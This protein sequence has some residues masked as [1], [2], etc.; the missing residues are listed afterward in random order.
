MPAYAPPKSSRAKT[1]L[2]VLIL[3]V[4][5]VLL[6]TKVFLDPHFLNSF[7]GDILLI[8]LNSSLVG[9]FIQNLHHETTQRKNITLLQKQ[10]EELDS[11]KD[12]FINMAAHELRAPLTAIKGFL[13]MVIGGD[14]GVISPEA[15]GFLVDSAVST[16]RMIRLVN[17]MLNVSR[18]EENRMFYQDED[19]HIGH[20]AHG[21]YSEFQVEAERKAL[22]FGVEMANTVN[23]L[24]FSDGD[25]LHEVLV[26]FV[27]NAIKYTEK[28]SVT[29]RI[30]NPSA[31][32][33]RL[34]VIDTGSG[35]SK[36]EQK[37]LFQKFYRV[38]AKVGKTIGTGLG[39]YIS[40][41]LIE[42]YG[43]T[44]GVISK[45]NNGSTFWFELPTK[46]M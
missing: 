6:A 26:N 15:K 33:V 9:L 32:K 44:I 23:D 25:K 28:G 31:D 4:I 46:Q 45:E 21:V 11:K 30:T 5:T 13:S 19:V 40:K 10:L 14:A 35:I 16:E 41:L 17:N 18:I 29:I 37:K 20:T 38:E 3:L 34:E 36:E 7:A 8:L 1:V 12:E 39:L 43:G 42:K 24:V 27:S 22:H 2:I